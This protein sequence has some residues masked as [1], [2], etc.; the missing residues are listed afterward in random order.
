MPLWPP[1]ISVNFKGVGR[2]CTESL[3]S[4]WR[5]LEG[6]LR[7]ETEEQ[8]SNQ[9]SPIEVRLFGRSMAA[10]EEQLAK[11][12]WPIEVRLFGRSMAVREE[13]PAKA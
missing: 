10:R 9:P 2:G 8:P 4:W 5:Y 6:R 1:D 12:L 7:R 3:P 11:A 13:Q